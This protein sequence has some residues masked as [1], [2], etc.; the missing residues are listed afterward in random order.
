[1]SVL[2]ACMQ[3]KNQRR[4]L[5][6]E[7]TWHPSLLPGS[8]QA[9]LPRA[10]ATICTTSLHQ[11]S[12]SRRATRSLVRDI[13]GSARIPLYSCSTIS[14]HRWACTCTLWYAYN[15]TCPE[16]HANRC[17]DQA[18]CAPV[19]H[20]GLYSPTCRCRSQ[21]CTAAS[22]G[23]L[24]EPVDMCIRREQAERLFVRQVIEFK[25]F[26][27]YQGTF[28]EDCAAELRCCSA[29]PLPSLAHS[30]HLINPS[31]ELVQPLELLLP[32]GTIGLRYARTRGAPATATILKNSLTPAQT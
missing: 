27:V 11:A 6:E 26:A 16:H 29:I 19:A 32:R 10:G 31:A 21:Q 20:V 22:A 12:S 17:G 18:T 2:R 28:E 23:V 13:T 25:R 4:G 15:S 3:L 9:W 7:N 14:L 5:R 30:P 24:V 8:L 1:M